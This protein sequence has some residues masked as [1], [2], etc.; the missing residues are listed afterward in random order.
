VWLAAPVLQ[1][2][3]QGADNPLHCDRDFPLIASVEPKLALLPA[4][5]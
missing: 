5:R 3:L 4:G 2:V 1:E